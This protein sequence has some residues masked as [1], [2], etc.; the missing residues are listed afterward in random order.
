MDWEGGAYSFLQPAVLP[1]LCCLHV[2]TGR[3]LVAMSASPIGDLVA[4]A[5][6]AGLFAVDLLDETAPAAQVCP[7]TPATSGVLALTWNSLTRDLYGSTQGGTVC[8]F[9]HD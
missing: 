7:G 1:D 4:V 9:A 5:S 3:P 8:A 6:S 2:L